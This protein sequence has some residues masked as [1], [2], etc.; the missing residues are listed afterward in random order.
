MVDLSA[1]LTFL[2][3]SIAIVIVPGPTVTVIIANSMRYGARAGLLNDAGTQAGLAVMVAVLAVGL[4][5]I[6]EGMG[7]A[8][9][10]LRIAGAAYLIWLG[11]KLWRSNGNLGQV[12]TKAPGG[13]FF[14]QGVIVIW[15]NPKALLFFGAFIPQFVDPVGSTVIQTLIFGGTFMA[16]AAILDGAYAILAGRTGSL[17]SRG[18]IRFVERFSG[19]CLIG[20]GLWLALARR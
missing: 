13:S 16:V 6:V 1:W 2:L 17:L 11:I 10:I 19:T 12:D 8:F 20:G 4:S 18:N 9:E 15:S 5:A 3:A 14:W 7:F